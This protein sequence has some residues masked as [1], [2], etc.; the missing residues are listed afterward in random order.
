MRWAN[1]NQ[2]LS[3]LKD[4]RWIVEDAMAFVKKEVKIKLT[5][6]EWL[7]NEAEILIPK[8]AGNYTLRITGKAS[9]SS[10][11]DLK[12]M[13]GNQNISGKECFEIELAC[14]QF[15]LSS[16]EKAIA[17]VISK[18]YLNP[19]KSKINFAFQKIFKY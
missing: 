12:I 6:D 1:E 10:L 14:F 2:E 8:L 4:I 18:S 17:K 7:I 11:K 19:L 13:L 5:E 15:N 3:N 16:P 9:S